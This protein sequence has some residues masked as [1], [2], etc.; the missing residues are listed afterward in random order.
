MN[1]DNQLIQLIKKNPQEGLSAAIDLYGS[2]IKWIVIKIIGHWNSQDIE[3]CIS[4]IFVKLW[5]NIDN[6]KIE[7]NISLKSYLCG[8][9]RHT[10]I[11]YLRKAKLHFEIIPIEEND[12]G[13]SVDFTDELAK[14]TNCLI[15]QEAVDALP[16][17]DREIFILRYYFHER[18]NSIAQS[19][20][21][22]PKAVENKLY[23][24]KKVL[25]D[26]LIERGII[27]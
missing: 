9:A 6:F 17:P 19:L 24:G 8:I 20:C 22:S 11:D 23:R 12:I 4:D 25:R 10:A 13:L 1:D 5:M 26:S 7:S 15:L 3:E 21:L 27:I 14:Q 18:I 2:T 16:E